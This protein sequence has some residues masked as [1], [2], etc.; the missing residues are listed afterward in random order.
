[1]DRQFCLA[2]EAYDYISALPDFECPA[3]PDANILCYRL[4]D[5]DD[6]AHLAIRDALIADGSFH[7]S[8]AEINGRRYLRCS[9]MNPDT[10]MEDVKGM[11]ERVR[12]AALA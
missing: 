3:R 8:T 4:R 7:L 2:R 6:A 5:R 11:I 9:F 12:K 10:T 1:V